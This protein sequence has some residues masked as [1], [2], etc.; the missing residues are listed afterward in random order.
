MIFLFHYLIIRLVGRL[1]RRFQNWNVQG[2][3]IVVEGPRIGQM[4]VRYI[5]HCR[6]RTLQWKVELCDFVSGQ[7]FVQFIEQGV[8]QLQLSVDH[9]ALLDAAEMKSSSIPN[10]TTDISVKGYPCSLNCTKAIFSTIVIWRLN[11]L[12]DRR[13]I[14]IQRGRFTPWTPDLP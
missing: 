5:G 2:R 1:I 11:R 12:A 14:Y 6:G 10:C 7:S 9:I 13:A 4:T 8:R 3:G